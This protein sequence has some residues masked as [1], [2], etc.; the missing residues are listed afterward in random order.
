MDIVTRKQLNILIQ[1]AE[2]DKNFAVAERELIYKIAR[3]KN[4]PLEEVE[5]L[6]KKPEPIGSLG[7][8]S[9]NQRFEYLFSCIKLILADQKIFEAELKFARNIAIK[10]GFKHNVVDLMIEKIENIEKSEL[11]KIVLQA[12]S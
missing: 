12:Y 11:Q 2:A 4:F 6:I 9:A 3:E 10:L 8:L 5:K 1:L 7:A